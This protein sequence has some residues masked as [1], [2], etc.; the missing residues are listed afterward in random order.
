MTALERPLNSRSGVC[1][2]IWPL[3]L[4]LATFAAT[5]TVVPVFTPVATTDDWGYTLLVEALRHE[6]RLVVYPIVVATSLFQVFWGLLFALPFGVSFG[7][8]RLSTLVM[9]SAGAVA[10]YG[11]LD[12]LGVGRGR[13]ALGAASYL[14]NPLSFVLSY[15]FMT[16]PHLTALVTI[17]TYGYARG[18]AGTQERPGA[19]WL[20]STAAACAF[21]TRQQGALIPVGVIVFLLISGRLR[22]E[23]AS[24]ALVFRV[25]GPGTAALIG[26]VAWL[27][28]V[29]DVPDI[30]REFLA[31]AREEGL[32]GALT[33]ARHLPVIEAM[34][35]G[36]FL[37]PLTAALLPGLPRVFAG[38][39]RRG[40]LLALVTATSLLFGVGA[41]WSDGRKFPYV[42]Q[43]LGAG[44]LG[45][46]DIRGSR[47]RVFEQPWFDAA[48]LVCLASALVAIA[49]VSRAAFVR[50][51]TRRAGAGLVASIAL[52]QAIGVLPPSF[53]YLDRGYSLDRYLLPLLPL[54]IALLLWTSC[55]LRMWMPIG[56]AVIAVFAAFSVAG[57]RDYLVFIERIWR[58]AEETQAAGARRDQLDAGA[59]WDGYHLYLDG[60]AKGLDSPRTTDGPWW[61]EIY[62]P[63]TDS[64]YVI[65]GRPQPGYLTVRIVLVDSW[66]LRRDDVRIYVQHRP[67]SP[68]PPLPREDAASP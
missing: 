30:Q 16:D 26:Y 36:L 1:S 39:G 18:L 41:F 48:T 51:D 33:L 59:G 9:S 37:L 60:L 62:A 52:W 10:L 13:R 7:A 25:A 61:T 38:M 40:S 31:N 20:G 27:R 64:T 23:R 68:W 24:A 19:L 66:L 21:L 4:V 5:A 53:E 45:P 43:F 2:G 47:P 50:G 57:T 32:P 49:I 15:T 63:I 29:N 3:L 17:S 44:G 34:Y 12:E 28:W 58:V 46:A 67:D 42:P 54:V 11:L 56:W 55:D 14:F 6:G 65:S 22:R 35:A 8:L